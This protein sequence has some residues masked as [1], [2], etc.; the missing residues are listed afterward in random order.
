MT[1]VATGP[2]LPDE[3]ILMRQPDFD[4]REEAVLSESEERRL[5]Q[6]ELTPLAQSKIDTRRQIVYFSAQSPGRSLAV[7]PFRY[8]NCWKPRWN[9]ASG[10]LLRADVALLAVS[11][12]K[13]V[14]VELEWEGGYGANAHCLDEDADL[15]GQA[16]SAA[17]EI[18]Y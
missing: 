2:A 5:P 6:G 12:E 13:S 9:G 4:P 10:A 18:P 16:C 17:I 15:V 7:L 1:R 3:L 11:F 8:S 14:D